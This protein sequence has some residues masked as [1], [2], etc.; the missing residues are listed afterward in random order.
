L[1]EFTRLIAE[2]AD[3]SGT[4]VDALWSAAY[5]EPVRVS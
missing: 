3:G 1:G 5:G 4:P 2:G